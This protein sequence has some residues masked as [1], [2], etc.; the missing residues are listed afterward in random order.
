M[1][2]NKYG[3]TIDFQSFCADYFAEEQPIHS[4]VWAGI[5][6]EADIPNDLHFRM[7]YLGGTVCLARK[8]VRVGLVIH[9]PRDDTSTLVGTV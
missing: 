3:H 9:Q 4:Q 1:E 6:W 2:E 5:N 8:I 7:K